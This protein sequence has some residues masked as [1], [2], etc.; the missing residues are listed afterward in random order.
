MLES[1]ENKIDNEIYFNS[2]TPVSVAGAGIQS[3]GGNIIE[4]Q[5]KF[6][7]S[8]NIMYSLYKD[9]SVHTTVFTE[10]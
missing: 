6:N 10:Y 8:I 7:H 9:L 2:E 1:A 5:L 3:T 4:Y